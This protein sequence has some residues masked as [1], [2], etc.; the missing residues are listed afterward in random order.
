MRTRVRCCRATRTLLLS[1]RC[2]ARRRCSCCP[3]RC[4]QRRRQQVRDGAVLLLCSQCSCCSNAAAAPA[5]RAL[6]ACVRVSP[7]LSRATPP[8]PSLSRAACRR[9]ARVHCACAVLCC[10]VLCC[11]VLCCAVLRCA[12]AEHAPCRAQHA[13]R[14]AQHAPRT[15]QH[16]TPPSKH[17][18]RRAPQDLKCQAH[19]AV[20]Q[21]RTCTRDWRL[22]AWCTYQQLVRAE[23][24]CSPLDARCVA[25]TACTGTWHVRIRMRTRVD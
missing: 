20:A 6:R 16:S 1:W 22:L 14:I 3:P 18:T 8:C 15:A 25:G 21:L 24:A 17:I 13:P 5:S 10:A 23:H 19:I 2:R 7:A 12:T 11:A 9:L 4:P